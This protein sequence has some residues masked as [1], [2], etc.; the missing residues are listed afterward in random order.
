MEYQQTLRKM[1]KL[2]GIGLHSGDKV[3]LKIRPGKPETGIVFRRVDLSPIVTIDALAENVSETTLATVL[4]D[5][6][7]SISTIEHCMAALFALGVDNAIVDVDG[8]EAPILDGSSFEYVVA[9][10]K[11]GLKM[12]RAPRRK[13]VIKKPL[14]IEDGDKFTI[15]RPHNGF[16]ITYSIEFEQG[17]PGEQHFVMD[18]TSENFTKKLCRARTFGFLEEVEMLRQ[19]GKARGASMDNA[20][21]LKDGKVLNPNGLRMPNEMVR[22]KMLDAVGDFALAGAPISGHLIVHKGGH[23]L[24]RRL[25]VALMEHKDAWEWETPVVVQK[26]NLRPLRALAAAAVHA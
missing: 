20:V 22:H 16:R 6:E 17:F 9:I 23:E 26:Q 15:L 2:V 14:R 13:I 24:H 1:V 8:P 3:T 10:N 4:G 25:V 5:K 11:V 19:M 12:Q 21:A 7:A 18:I